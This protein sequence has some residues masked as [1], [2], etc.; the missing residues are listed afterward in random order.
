MFRSLR[1]QKKHR[2]GRGHTRRVHA[3]RQQNTQRRTPDYGDL[4]TV[5]G[6]YTN[7]D[8]NTSSS[9][10]STDTNSETRPLLQIRTNTTVASNDG[11]NSET[12]PLLDQ[13]ATSGDQQPCQGSVSV[14]GIDSE[15]LRA[16]AA[17]E[18]LLNDELLEIEGLT[19][20]VPST[21]QKQP[22]SSKTTKNKS[23]R[24][25]GGLKITMNDPPSV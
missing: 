7:D 20:K 11:S 17:V 3:Q 10:P 12:K 6:D 2:S 18:E 19:S 16:T 22:S 13:D 15:V 5:L 4:N 23:N 1:K 25:L 21:K 9:S 24:E 14:D 8:V